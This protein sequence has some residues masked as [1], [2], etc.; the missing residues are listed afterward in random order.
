MLRVPA[1]CKS[2]GRSLWDDVNPGHGQIRVLRYLADDLI[3]FRILPG[4]YL[5]CPVNSE[6][7][8]IRI[9]VTEKIHSHG[10][11]E[12]QDHALPTSEKMPDPNDQS[13][14][15]AQKERRLKPIPHFYL[16]P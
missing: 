16:P 13:S 10:Q 4:R 5:P 3:D 6:D 2:V 15:N 14:H 1:G 9:P 8:L 11:D 7:K 12:G